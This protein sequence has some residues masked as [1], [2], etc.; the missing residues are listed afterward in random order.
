MKEALPA[1]CNEENPD[2]RF[3]K[4]DDLE[5]IA[6]VRSLECSWTFIPLIQRRLNKRNQFSLFAENNIASHPLL[7]KQTK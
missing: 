4:T 5:L 6:L 3:A 1:Y 7:P 2:L